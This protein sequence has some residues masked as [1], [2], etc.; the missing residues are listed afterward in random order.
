MEDT[1][2]Q[3]SLMEVENKDIE[4]E[5]LLIWKTPLDKIPELP[6]LRKEVLP[7]T[8]QPP[9]LPKDHYTRFGEKLLQLVKDRLLT[10]WILDRAGLYAI[11]GDHF[12]PREMDTQSGRV[13]LAYNLAK[14][15]KEL[16]WAAAW[17]IYKRAGGLLDLRETEEF[18]IEVEE[19]LPEVFQD[20]QKIQQDKQYHFTSGQISTKRRIV[21]ISQDQGEMLK[22]IG[23]NHKKGELL[24]STLTALNKKYNEL[25]QKVENFKKMPTS[26]K[27]SREEPEKEVNKE[28]KVKS[29]K[30]TDWSSIVS[31][32]EQKM[33]SRLEKIEKRVDN[34]EINIKSL[35][36]RDQERYRK[37]QARKFYQLRQKK[38]K[39]LPPKKAEN[40]IIQEE[41][42][43]A[44]EVESGNYSA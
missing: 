22:W 32:L 23:M 5:G 17:L 37:I 31:E 21:Q 25:K 30:T 8:K 1:D 26:P 20:L 4:N 34:S 2:T 19:K 28:T 38:R 42:S 12:Y 11:L 6:Y 33:R 13:T 15:P 29:E 9:L 39:K 10:M 36:V 27:T 16:E 14:N 44:D 40:R 35:M 3:I 24:T 7:W 18:E 43:A 41:D